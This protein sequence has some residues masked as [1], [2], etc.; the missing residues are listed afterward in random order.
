MCRKPPEKLR[1]AMPPIALRVGSRIGIAVCVLL[2]LPAGACEQP[3]AYCN[4]DFIDSNGGLVIPDNWIEV[5]TNAF[6]GC[7]GLRSVS[8]A[9]SHVAT[10]G[11]EAFSHCTALASMLFTD[12]IVTTVGDSAF[13]GCTALESV[14]FTGSSVTMVG[15]DVSRLCRALASVSFT[16]S[17]VT[18]VGNGA[19]KRCS[20]SALELVSFTGSNVTV[21]GPDVFRWCTSL[22]SVSF[23]NSSVTTVDRAFRGCSALESVS[24]TDS[25]VAFLDGDAFLNCISLQMVTYGGS[26]N[27]SIVMG[28]PTGGAINSA[29]FRE[30]GCGGADPASFAPPGVCNC[31]PMTA[32]NRSA[33]CNMDFGIPSAGRAQQERMR[34]HAPADG[35]SRF[36]TGHTAIAPGFDLSNGTALA[37]LFENVRPGQDGRDLVAFSV[38]SNYAAG[39]PQFGERQGVSLGDALFVSLSTGTMSLK[40]D[41]P[42]N[43][44]VSLIARTGAGPAEHTAPVV[45]LSW[46]VRVELPGTFGLRQDGPGGCG[47]QYMAELQGLITEVLRERAP[48]D[49]RHDVDT[50]VV[51]PGINTK[52]PAATSRTSS[53]TRPPTTPA[54]RRPRS[55]CWS[56]TGTPTP[57]PISATP[58]STP[59]RAG[60]CSP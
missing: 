14:S 21:V 30:H 55:E 46:T 32:D 4:S 51:L 13:K 35:S 58:R 12:S 44:T 59:T 60:R 50:T 22:A 19:F 29:T 36:T 28:N 2:L 47:E 9:G 23:A 24:F 48:R 37:D 54:S 34:T 43:H 6:N 17:S 18:T 45:V 57:P 7:A 11:R 52:R 56:R 3:D 41:N 27:Q 31:V 38:V 40:M 10:V 25:I 26:Y 20:C 49:D 8:F 15:P 39:D 1:A 16:N 33:S 53:S 42:G 5:P